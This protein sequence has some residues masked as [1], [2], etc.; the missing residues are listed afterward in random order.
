MVV[1]VLYTGT[2]YRGTSLAKKQPT[3]TVRGLVILVRVRVFEANMLNDLLNLP[4]FLGTFGVGE[5]GHMLTWHKTHAERM[6]C[7]RSGA[8]A[9][10]VRLSRNPLAW[11]GEGAP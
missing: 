1:D 6:Q 5:G 7:I 4:F 9:M 3:S 10:R 2:G 11:D 8:A